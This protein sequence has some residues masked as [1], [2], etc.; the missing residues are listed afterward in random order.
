MSAHTALGGG[1]EFDLIRAMLA[2]YGDAAR[3][4]GDDA[5]VLDI[6]PGERVVVST[7]VAVDQ[8]H[9][10][11]EW[12]SAAEI[13]Y[14]SAMAALSDLAAMA[15]A[16]RGMLVT[17][18]LPRAWHARARGLVLGIARA[19]RAVDAPVVGGDV[20]GGATLSIGVTVVGSTAAPLRRD[21]A[22]PG[23]HVWVTGRLGAPGR[24]LRALL[25]GAAP[26]PDDRDRFVAPCARVRE[27]IWLAAHGATAAV[28]VSDGLAADLAHLAAAS[29]VRIVLA[30][31]DIPAVSG[32]TAEDAASSGEEYEI[33]L[34]GPAALDTAA[35][36]AAFGI[37]LTHIGTVV[38]PG[39]R[40]AGVAAERDG[41]QID[42]RPGFDHFAS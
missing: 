23:D 17:L 1:A 8:V 6:P 10:R 41:V 30:L 31:D 39:T 9:F 2:E 28:D 13:G 20:S 36:A 16:P 3:G 34:A 7:D 21:G 24:A 38:A 12:M 29:G 27:A 19:A 32:A 11:P 35:F 22:R 25:T 5:A 18:T 26:R 40:G 37:P 14:R 4:T 42:L 15:A 33:A